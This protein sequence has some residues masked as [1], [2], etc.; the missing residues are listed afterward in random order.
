MSLN[1][2]NGKQHNEKFNLHKESGITDMPEGGFEA[3]FS[4][5]ASS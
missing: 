5:F 3:L 4:M 2:I 1:Q